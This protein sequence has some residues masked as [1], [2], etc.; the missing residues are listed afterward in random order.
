MLSRGSS[1][2]A[3]EGKCCDLVAQQPPTHDQAHVSGVAPLAP[4]ISK[5]IRMSRGSLT[6]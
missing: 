5:K 4:N 3:W 2:S 6:S 1:Q